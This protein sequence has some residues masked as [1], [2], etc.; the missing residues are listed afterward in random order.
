[1]TMELS[2]K[3]IFITNTFAEAH[4]EE[5]L[6]LWMQFIKEVPYKKR[7]EFFGSDNIHYVNWLKKQNNPIVM[8]FLNDNIVERSF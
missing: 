8:Q 7:N 1:M 4:P 5:H 2:S 6:E 3:A